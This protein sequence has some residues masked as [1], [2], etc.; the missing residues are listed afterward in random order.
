MGGFWDLARRGDAVALIEGDTSVTYAELDALVAAAADELGPRRLAFVRPANTIEFVVAY[1]GA[2]RARHPVLFTD[3]YDLRRRPR[4]ASRSCV[5]VVDFGFDGLDEN[6][7]PVATTTSRRTPS[8]SWRRSVSPPTTGPSRRCRCTTAMAYRSCTATCR[9][10][11][12]WCSPICR[13]SI[14]VSGIWRANTSVTSFAGVPHTFELLERSASLVTNCR[15]C[16]TSLRPVDGWRRIAC[17]TCSV[18]DAW[19]RP[20]RHV[21][22]DRS[23]R[24]HGVLAPA[25]AATNPTAIGVAIPGGDLCIDDGELVYRGDNVMLGYATGPDRLGARSR[26]RRTA[27]RR[28]RPAK[29]VTVCSRLSDE[30]RGSSNHSACVSTSTTSSVCWRPT[31]STA[32]CTGDDEQLV[33]GVV[34]PVDRNKVRGRPG[35]RDALPAA[36]TRCRRRARCRATARE[37]QGRLCGCACQERRTRRRRRSSA[38]VRDVFNAVLGVAA[39]PARHVCGSGGRLVV[40]CRDVDLVGRRDR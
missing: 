25:L 27:H 26:H 24:A 7:A 23:H 21:R 28:S 29:R 5:V 37:R 18:G 1:L 11:P 31:E 34:A 32:L 20:C 3:R 17:S 10:V 19:F 16:A 33:V 4:V 15:R 13:S 12:A 39:E 35:D 8:R 40:V 2:L 9:Q 14:G 6:G 36:L 30:R 22:P 38:T